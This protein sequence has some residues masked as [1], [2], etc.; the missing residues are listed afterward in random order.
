MDTIELSKKI[1]DKTL[2]LGF[3][4]CGITDCAP[5]DSAVTRAYETY[6]QEERHAD[7]NY[8]SRYQSI[9]FNPKQLVPQ[10]KSIIVVLASYYTLTPYN[11]RPSRYRIA[12]YAW[13]QDY[14]KVIKQRLKMLQQYITM[15]VP[16]S[17]NRY[18]V[19]TA[20]VM[21]KHLAERAGLGWIGKNTLLTNQHGSYHFI[22]TLFTSVGLT[23]DQPCY[24]LHPCASCSL[25]QNACPS[26]ALHHYGM[27]ARKCFAYQSIENHNDI[28]AHFCSTNYIYGCDECQKACPFNKHAS[29]TS[30]TEF[31]TNPFLLSFTDKQWE[32]ISQ[33]DFDRIFA[34]SAIKR[35]G[36]RKFKSNITHAN[37][38]LYGKKE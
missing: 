19:D 37:N 27:D 31:G 34:A 10:A 6:L 23:Y 9:R 35:I 16:D 13:G 38:Y 28:D 33:E 24:S 4:A 8:L 3:Y 36:Y 15:L 1:K 21:E 26:Q 7:M 18:F 12:R 30:I 5:I 32:N 2:E 14:H 11:T 17:I 29:P 20:P 25:C 22:A